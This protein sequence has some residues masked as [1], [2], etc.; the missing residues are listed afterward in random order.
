MGWKDQNWIQPS[1]FDSHKSH[2][3]QLVK[4]RLLVK[5]LCQDLMLLWSLLL[6]SVGGLPSY[7][8]TSKSLWV[9]GWPSRYLGRVNRLS[10]YIS[11]FFQP[12]AKLMCVCGTASQAKCVLWKMT[13]FCCHFFLGCQSFLVGQYLLESYLLQV[14]FAS[15]SDDYARI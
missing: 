4:T 2:S 14:L 7:Q 11:C 6:L 5:Y 10:V 8:N 9:F 1:K 15:R 3:D 13:S 12:S